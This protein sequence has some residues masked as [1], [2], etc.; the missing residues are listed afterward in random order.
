MQSKVGISKG[1]NKPGQP[2]ST[3][4]AQVQDFIRKHEDVLHKNS[5]RGPNG[6]ELE[7]K[8]VYH[9]PMGAKVGKQWSMKQDL[10]DAFKNVE[11][12]SDLV[13]DNDLNLWEFI[14]TATSKDYNWSMKDT[15]KEVRK[16]LSTG[17]W[18]LPLY[19]FPE[20]TV[21]TPQ[22]TPLADAIPR[23]AIDR[24]KVQA[25]VRTDT[26]P[27]ES[28][29]EGT[30]AFPEADDT[31][32]TPS[33]YEFSVQGY[34]R[35][36][37]VTELMNLS[38]ADITNSVNEVQSAQMKAIRIYEED[39]LLYGQKSNDSNGF[40]GF[41]DMLKE[42]ADH[43]T[44]IDPSSIS[45]YEDEVKDL[46]DKKFDKQGGER[47][48]AIA[49][50]NH[51]VFSELTKELKSYT[52]YNEPTEN[53]D[54]GFRVLDFEDVPVMKSH[55]MKSNSTVESDGNEVYFYVVDLGV[56]S[57]DMLQDAT[58]KTVTYDRPSERFWTS[59]Y[60][61]LASQGKDRITA[62]RSAS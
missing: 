34:G 13:P 22:K 2:V 20:V 6:N 30:D 31:Y 8:T 58:L 50:T 12:K 17:D 27:A 28:F 4:K 55:R 61:T 1:W 54:F 18:N 48:N 60:G 44:Q 38:S 52:R 56:H 42:D 26:A 29:A 9:D 25:H 37:E 19:F 10:F 24:H 40:K 16:N 41:R 59:A 14:S 62:L 3:N 36:N 35:M 21:V 57:M 51:E 46:L 23:R 49:V 43:T 7:H 15:V 33:D 45:S 32:A 53:L 39:Q 5:F 11:I 47:Q